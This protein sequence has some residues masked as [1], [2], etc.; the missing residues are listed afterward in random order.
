MPEILPSLGVLSNTDAWTD[1]WQP[2][3]GKNKV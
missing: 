2:E 1:V 3:K